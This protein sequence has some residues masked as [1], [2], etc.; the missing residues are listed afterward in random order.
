MKR[1]FG[2]PVTLWP[3]M[4]NR[5]HVYALPAP[6]LRSALGERQRVL[7]AFD[8]CSIQPVD[9][10]HATVQQFAVTSDEVSPEDMDAFMARLK[11][12]AAETKSFSVELGEPEA[13]DYSLGVRGTNTPPWAKLTAAVR[14]AAA[15]T[16]NKS[17]SLPGAPFQPSSHFGVRPGRRQY[18]TY[19]TSVRPSE[20]TCPASPDHQRSA[21]HSGP[22]GRQPRR[23]HLGHH[24]SLPFQRTP[25]QIIEANAPWLPRD[26]HAEGSAIGRPR[27][28]RAPRFGSAI[29][30]H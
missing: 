2:H 21:L 24:I 26:V 12:L 28:E 16:I 17:Q 13:D 19:S 8:Y 3:S 25:G 18:R 10:L 1:F 23:L 15:D 30:M 5:L 9:Y 7:A 4:R 11:S 6:D 20:G 29:P 14:D 22:P 27:R